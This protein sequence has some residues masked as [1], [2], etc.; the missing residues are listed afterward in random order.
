MTDAISTSYGIHATPK[1]A[2]VH[3]DSSALHIRFTDGGFPDVTMY[4]DDRDLAL[5]LAAAINGVLAQHKPA[6]EAA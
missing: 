1:R 4:C 3:P 2:L 6:E 5:A